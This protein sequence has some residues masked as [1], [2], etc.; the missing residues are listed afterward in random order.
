MEAVKILIAEDEPFL[1]KIVKESLELSGFNVILVQDGVKAYATFRA[2]Q[3]TVCI[4]DIMMPVKDGFSLIEDVRRIDQQ[5]PIIFLTAKSLTNDVVKGFELGC[6]D[7][8]KKPFSMEELIVRINALLSRPSIK[9]KNEIKEIF[10]IGDFLFNS[11]NQELN[12]PNGTI[13]LSFRESV[14]LKLLAENK[15]EV[16]NRK[17]ALEVVWGEDNFFNARSMD[18]F[19][20]KLRKHLREDSRIEIVNIRGIGYKLIINE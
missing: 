2:W 16:L 20:T 11:K 1:G 5:V 7:Y 12:K 19:I 3:P 10:E 15:N 18:V 4:F 8:L 14:L 17:L 9:N 6:N 13:K